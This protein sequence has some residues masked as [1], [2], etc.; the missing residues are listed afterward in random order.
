MIFP[1]K[2]ASEQERRNALFVRRLRSLRAQKGM[3]QR[4]L[5]PVLGVRPQTISLYESGE[6][7]PNVATLSKMADVFE[8]SGDYLMGRSEGAAVDLNGLSQRAHDTAVKKGWY[9]TGERPFAELLC[10]VHSE[11]SE[12]LEEYRIGRKV[13]ESYYDDRGKPCGVPSELADIV[14]RV[15]DIAG[16]YGI[17]LQNAVEEK[18]VYN[19]TRPQRH[20]GKVV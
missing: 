3:S 18:M 12:A 13:A 19:A 8:V 7:L 5:A 1:T 10:L 6:T 9:D 4:D 16:L 2:D 14:I 11:V 17:D 15:A 20:G